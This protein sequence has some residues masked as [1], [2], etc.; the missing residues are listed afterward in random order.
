LATAA[1]PA[2]YTEYFVP[3]MALNPTQPCP[4][5]TGGAPVIDPANPETPVVP[6]E[7]G[8]PEATQPAETTPAP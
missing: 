7:T 4:I 2:P 8:A 6:G 5:H 1:C 3:G